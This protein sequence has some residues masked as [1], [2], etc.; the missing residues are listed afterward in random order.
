M[1]MEAMKFTGSATSCKVFASDPE[2]TAEAQ[3]RTFLDCPAFAGCHIR[4]MPDV[5][6]GAGAVI[7]FTSPVGPGV[8]PNVIGVDIGC[9][10]LALPLTDQPIDFPAFDERVRNAVPSGFATRDSIHPNVAT[11]FHGFGLGKNFLGFLADV[12]A[13]SIHIG[14]D[15][16]RAINSIGTLGGGNH[17][18]ELDH[19]AKTGSLWLALH[20]GSRN[21][22]LRIANF[23]QDIA[24]RRHPEA[25]ALAWLEGEEAQ[26]YLR[27]MRLAQ[28]YARLNR[29]AMA[30][31]IAVAVF[32]DRRGFDFNSRVESVHNYIDDDGMIR[33]GAI[34]AKQ[35]ESVVIP[36]NMRDG[37]ILGIGRGNPDWNE[38]APHGAGRRMGRMEAKRRLSLDDFRDTMRAAGVWSSCVGSDTLDEAPDAYKPAATVEAWLG[39]T[40]EIVDRLRPVYNFKASEEERR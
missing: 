38:S 33:K 17:F 7:G 25:G 6:A 16:K 3:I 27:D 14:G 34:S 21:F 19:S 18:I 37:M 8:C 1:D 35:G 5:H 2:A 13:L 12:E 30:D 22:G 4:I 28:T 20:S 29:I 9:G 11:L 10:V 31:A 15:P 24:K 26:D 39:A 40:V 32:G 36:W 23:H